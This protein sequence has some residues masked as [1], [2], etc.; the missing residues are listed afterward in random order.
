MLGAKISDLGAHYNWDASQVW[1]DSF[2]AKDDPFPTTLRLGI[3]YRYQNYFT[4]AT[5]LLSDITHPSR[6]SEAYHIKGGIEGGYTF[7]KG[8]RMDFRGGWEGNNPTLGW[9]ISIPLSTRYHLEWNY[10]YLFDS[11]SFNNGSGMSL[12]FIF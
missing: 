6:S 1:G 8:Y 4:I 3:S 5:E 9:G 11:K 7:T 10:T 2:G 12:R